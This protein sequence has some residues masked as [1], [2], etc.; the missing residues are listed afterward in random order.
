MGLP[1]GITLPLL[2]YDMGKYKI[3]SPNPIASTGLSL[4]NV[5]VP[6]PTSS[7][8]SDLALDT[9]IHPEGENTER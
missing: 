7:N 6:V 1:T 3:P 2:R 8:L 4:V 5:R 9:G